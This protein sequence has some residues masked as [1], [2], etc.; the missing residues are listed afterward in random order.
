VTSEEEK[1]KP[2]S[3]RKNA[4]AFV[5]NMNVQSLLCYWRVIKVPFLWTSCLATVHVLL[6]LPLKKWQSLD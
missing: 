2:I 5:S 4:H 1:G 6:C 3:Y